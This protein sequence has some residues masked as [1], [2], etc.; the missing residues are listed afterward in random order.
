MPHE[1]VIATNGQTLTVNA[2]VSH[3]TTS[4]LAATASG[5]NDVESTTTT[6]ITGDYSLFFADTATTATVTVKQIDGNTL[7]SQVL[8]VGPGVG[9]RRIAPTPDIY[10]VGADTAGSS[11]ASSGAIASTFPRTYPTELLAAQASGTLHL[12][13]IHLQKGTL[14]SSISFT[15]GTT[16]LSGGSN[17]LFGLYDSALALLATSADDTTTAWAASTIKTLAMT[18]PYTTTYTGLHYLGLSITATTR[19]TM[20]GIAILANAVAAKTPKLAGTSTTGLTTAL[21]ATA[22]AITGDAGYCYAYVS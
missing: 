14:V 6:T 2:S 12:Y 15:T 5:T 4:A 16:A 21:P 18:T 3:W 10:Q 19:P 17:Q 7:F 22:A 9:T 1:T 13:A 8:Q 20:A 11:L